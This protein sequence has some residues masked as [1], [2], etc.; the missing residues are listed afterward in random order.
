MMTYGQAYAATQCG[1]R[2]RRASWKDGE[3]FVRFDGCLIDEMGY[4]WIPR[5]GDTEADDWG[6]FQ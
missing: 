2:I 1:G 3:R 6:L 4:P 5:P